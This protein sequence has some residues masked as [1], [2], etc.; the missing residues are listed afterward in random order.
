[1]YCV[2]NNS[3]PAF[4]SLNSFAGYE[5]LI[6]SSEVEGRPRN[7]PE[8]YMPRGSDGLRSK[9]DSL[10]AT[11]VR[12][13]IVKLL[14]LNLTF[15]C[16]QDMHLQ[17]ANSRSAYSSDVLSRASNSMLRD[18]SLSRLSTKGPGNAGHILMNSS[19]STA[20]SPSELTDATASS[21][22]E[23]ISPTESQTSVTK[24]SVSSR[25]NTSRS[26][27]LPPSRHGN[28]PTSWSTSLELLGP[29][30]QGSRASVQA[31]FVTLTR[32]S[33]SSFN[34]TLPLLQKLSIGD[35]D[36]LSINSF[37]SSTNV[38]TYPASFDGARDSNGPVLLPN[39]SS[40]P[41]DAPLDN[42]LAMR[43]GVQLGRHGESYARHQDFIP[44]GHPFSLPAAPTT[45]HGSTAHFS[46][47]AK[48][49]NHRYPHSSR[50]FQ[51]ANHIPSKQ[52]AVLETKRMK[53][54]QESQRLYNPQMQQFVA[55]AQANRQSN[56]IGYQLPNPT[57]MNAYSG[58]MSMPT[59][60]P[61]MPPYDSSA[62][63]KDQDSGTAVRSTLMQEFKSNSRSNKRY[64]LKVKQV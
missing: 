56:A 30:R 25:I 28:E 44:S 17:N 39:N 63:V 50:N 31:P 36:R 12:Y 8:Y 16:G 19:R 40:R 10:L 42:R 58:S 2:E 24:N 11:T 34:R 14:V 33:S 54:M 60:Q 59:F 41:L 6:S 1:M 5:S 27:S 45:H 22:N 29:S 38:K 9:Y 48:V 61:S 20:I 46:E 51:P 15:V 32:P 52:M 18:Q 21:W 23:Q 7:V 49:G 62:T 43:N 3:E 47:S 35:D 37:D 57:P 53:G 55:S 13:Y 64:D 4:Q 26:G